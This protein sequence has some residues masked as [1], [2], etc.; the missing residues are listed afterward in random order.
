MRPAIAWSL[1]FPLRTTPGCSKFCTF[2]T[3]LG[4]GGTRQATR[5]SGSP[6]FLPQP[7]MGA[8]PAGNSPRHRL[9]RTLAPS[10]GLPVCRKAGKFWPSFPAV[11]LLPVLARVCL[12]CV[13][14]YHK[15]VYSP[16]T[17]T[18]KANSYYFLRLPLTNICQFLKQ[19]LWRN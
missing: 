13:W 19:I 14:E 18:R 4:G 2:I 17:S 5:S 6:G 12:T 9:L 15:W 3:E 1:S 10:R 11:F 8:C 7:P 16:S